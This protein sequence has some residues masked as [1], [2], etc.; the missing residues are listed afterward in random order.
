MIDGKN[1]KDH[2]LTCQTGVYYVYT[3][4]EIL[5]MVDAQL[6]KW[7]RV[8]SLTNNL[9]EDV[10]SQLMQYGFCQ[11]QKIKVLKKAPFFKDPL[12]VEVR[13]SQIA[14]SASDAI[15]ILIDEA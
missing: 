15:H 13:G 4:L 8:S 14:I 12:L 1:D 6:G 10:K 9:S 11:G 7:Y 5:N 3:K 2:C